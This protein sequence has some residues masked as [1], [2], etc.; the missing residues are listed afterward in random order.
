MTL[1]K[2]PLPP[3]WPTYRPAP[4]TVTKRNSRQGAGYQL[5][6]IAIAAHWLSNGSEILPS[7]GMREIYAAKVKAKG[8][9]DILKH[10]DQPLHS[11]ARGRFVVVKQ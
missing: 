6:D 9:I 8:N 11:F 4:K 10:I 3:L 1:S 2:T 5:Q 7:T